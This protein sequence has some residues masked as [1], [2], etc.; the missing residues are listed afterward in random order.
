MTNHTMHMN[1]KQEVWKKG[2]GAEAICKAFPGYR[3]CNERFL[4]LVNLILVSR[5]LNPSGLPKGSRAVAGLNFLSMRR[6][7]VSYSQPI[8]F[9]RFEGK[10]VN[11]RL[12]VLLEQAKA[13]DL[14][15]KETEFLTCVLF[16]WSRNNSLQFPLQ[17]EFKQ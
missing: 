2:G 14:T 9:A 7:F 3:E 10:F 4:C 16:R 1:L 6:V 8:R 13:L 5:A 15:A 11:R 12:P 17:F